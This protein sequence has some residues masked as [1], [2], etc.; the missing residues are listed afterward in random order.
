[1]PLCGPVPL[2]AHLAL[3]PHE[4]SSCVITSHLCQFPWLCLPVRGAPISTHGPTRVAAPL[5]LPLREADS[6]GVT[7]PC[8]HGDSLGSAFLRGELSC[9]HV[10]P[11]PPPLPA[12]GHN[13]KNT[14]HLSLHPTYVRYV[15]PCMLSRIWV[16]TPYALSCI[17]MPPCKAGSVST[18]I[19]TG[20]AY[21]DTY[22]ICTI[23]MH[24]AIKKW[25]QTE[26]A[27]GTYKKV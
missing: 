11:P 3:P 8:P 4:T 27:Y 9:C 10:N 22:P 25:S 24:Y 23:K 12:S 14:Q 1:M 13:I 16:L 26:H 20:S 5:A 2:V 19:P 7:W 21:E 17:N 6:H 15:M 18:Q